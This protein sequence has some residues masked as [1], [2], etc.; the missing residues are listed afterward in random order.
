M[1]GE[2]DFYIPSRA[3]WW[4]EEI[5]DEKSEAV[6]NGLIQKRKI[7]NYR[8]KGL[9]GF[10]LNTQKHPFDDIKVRE[11][12]SYLFNFDELNTKLFYDQ[13][14]RINSYYPGSIFA[15]KNNP[16]PEYNPAKAKAFLKEA[17]WAK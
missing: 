17:G 5:S 11:A 2:F 9:S 6:K 16:K 7:Y 1:A 8:L 15:C 3:Q 12:M 13:Y 4:I 14:Q 10:A